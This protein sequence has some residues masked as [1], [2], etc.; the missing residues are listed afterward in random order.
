MLTFPAC[1]LALAALCATAIALVPTAKAEE[2]P[3]VAIVDGSEIRRSD[4]VAA[5]ELLPPRV[6]SLPL[7]M[8]FG[9]LLE[10]VIEAR[11]VTNEARKAGIQEE[12][13]VKIRLERIEDRIIQDVFLERYITEMVT[14]E[15]VRQRYEDV[16]AATPQRDEVRTRHILVGTKDEA[17]AIIRDLRAGADFAEIAKENSVGPSAPDGGDIGYATRDM[18]VTEFSN[19][20]FSL[21]PGQMSE[22]P[23]QTQFGWHVIK[24]VDRRPA[25]APSF[26]EM[27]D[28]IVKEMTQNKITVYFKELVDKA[29]IVRFNFDG[30]PSVAE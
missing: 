21:Q 2:D 19:V 8:I 16:A 10:R 17:E 12:A 6:Q 1:I 27:R 26:E 18:L 30:T 5:Q 7:D 20:A 28:Q 4:L 14:E 29:A 24:V 25:A 3:V 11:L 13:A 23:V 9:Q 22:V 15:M